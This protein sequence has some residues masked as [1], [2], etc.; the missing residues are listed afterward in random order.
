MEAEAATGSGPRS[1]W[2]LRLARAEAS[3]PFF[4]AMHLPERRRAVLLRLPPGTVPPAR[5]WPRCRGLEPVAVEMEGAPHVGVALKEPRFGDVFAALAEDL[6]RR[7]ELA[8]S[9][10]AQAVEF[11]GQLARWQ[12]FLAVAREGLSAEAQRGLWGEL[13]FLREHLLPIL[14]VS[15]VAGWTGGQA[16]HQDFCH[17]ATA[18][19]VKTTLAKQPQI[20][21]INSERQLDDTAWAALF[22]HVTSLDERES[23]GESL[24][25]L[26]ATLRRRHAEA[27]AARELLEEGLLAAGYLDHHADRYD[28]GYVVRSQTLLRVTSGF[29]RITERE[30]SPGI[31]NVSYGLAVASAEPFRVAPEALREALA[32]AEPTP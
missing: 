9:Q 31:G 26:V 18:I 5:Q 6:L 4:V 2:V 14:G 15:A 25:E 16:A 11:L 8:G 23:G 10:E 7:I 12:K 19:E 27:P 21:R 13:H 20:V 30:L 28:T 17:A 3:C 29:P 1:G 24:P 32:R 22:L